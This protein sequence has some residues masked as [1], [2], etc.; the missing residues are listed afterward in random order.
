MRENLKL[1][2]IGKNEQERLKIEKAFYQHFCDLFIEMIK[3]ITLSDRGV[4]K[5]FKVYN[6]E[7][8]QEYYDKQKSVLFMCGHYAS[9]EWLL[10]ICF[11]MPHT[12]FG[13][14]TR[15]SNPYF[16]SMVQR[17]RKRWGAVMINRRDVA[18]EIRK[19]Q[20]EG[21]LGVY[22]LASDQSPQIKSI[23]YWRPFLGVTVPVFTGAERMAKQ[24]DLPVV[25]GRLS[26]TKRGYYAVHVEPLIDQ[27]NQTQEH[28]ITDLF[29]EKIEQQIRENPAH[30]LWT[31]NRFKHKDK[32]PKSNP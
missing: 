27:P 24:Y 2:N 14:Y 18:E 17:V 13:I 29:V 12:G 22:G 23:N 32:A 1:A 30:Y 3:S 7:I 16:D 25:Y 15:L 21:I 26:K 6:A 11:H 5:H 4:Q 10:S 31:H 9:Y 8:L 28:E 19:H 20:N